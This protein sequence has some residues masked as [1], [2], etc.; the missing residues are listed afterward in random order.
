MFT[1]NFC[2]YILL[3]IVIYVIIIQIAFTTKFLKFFMKYSQGSVLTFHITSLVI[4]VNL[5]V[6]SQVLKF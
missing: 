1:S 3:L 2:N 5:D 6:T 4:T